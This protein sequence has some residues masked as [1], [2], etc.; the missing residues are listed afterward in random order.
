MTAVLPVLGVGYTRFT[1]S[2]ECLRGVFPIGLWFVV[3]VAEVYFCFLFL[4]CHGRTFVV[5]APSSFVPFVAL[6]EIKP[7][8]LPWTFT[9]R[10]RVW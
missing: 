3:V 10:V 9:G 1:L 6:F 4:F 2:G 8:F 5:S 7:P